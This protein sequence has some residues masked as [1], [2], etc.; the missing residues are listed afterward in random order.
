MKNFP[1]HYEELNTWMGKLGAAI[2]DV[3]RLWRVT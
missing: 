3:A 2:P 1:A